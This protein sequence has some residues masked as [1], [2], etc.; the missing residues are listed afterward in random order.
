LRGQ[1]TADRGQEG[2]KVELLPERHVFLKQVHVVVGGKRILVPALETERQRGE[3]Q[4]GT[5]DADPREHPPL[6]CQQAHWREEDGEVRLDEQEREEQAGRD[7]P[8]ATPGP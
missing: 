4:E 8:A 2:V 1:A 3:Q 6:S 5:P 7:R